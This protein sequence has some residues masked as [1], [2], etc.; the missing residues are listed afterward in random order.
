MQFVAGYSKIL[1]VSRRHLSK[2]VTADDANVDLNLTQHGTAPND[3]ISH[4][5]KR[6]CDLST[7]VSLTVSL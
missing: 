1:N 5:I 7:L 2:Q 6:T 3:L 4:R